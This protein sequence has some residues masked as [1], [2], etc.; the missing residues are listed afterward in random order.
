MRKEPAIHDAQGGDLTSALANWVED[1]ARHDPRSSGEVQVIAHPDTVEPFKA[2]LKREGL[3]T[4][5]AER[6]EE[7]RT[8]VPAGAWIEDR[9]AERGTVW[10]L[11]KAAFYDST[12]ATESLTELALAMVINLACDEPKAATA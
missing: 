2:W 12:R 3:H 8:I 5:L 4:P 10:V 7:E 11:S 6:P 1:V 9:N